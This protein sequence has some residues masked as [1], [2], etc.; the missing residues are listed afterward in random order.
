MPSL[1]WLK[2]HGAAETPQNIRLVVGLG[3]PGE[4]Y[5]NTRH[6][7]G[8]LALD[9]ILNDGDGYM[10]ARPGHDFK[11]EVFTWQKEKEKIQIKKQYRK[12]CVAD[13]PMPLLF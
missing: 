10:E 1:R 3:N 7:A 13:L 4:K 12:L 2:R 11:S 8:F 9:F 6:N 5:K